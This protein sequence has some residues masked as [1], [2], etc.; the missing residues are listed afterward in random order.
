M[1]STIL[2]IKFDTETRDRLKALGR[3]R[4]RATHWLIKRAVDQ[5]LAR[6]E[7]AERERLEDDVRWD[8]YQ[9]TAEAIPNQR[10][11]SWLDELA[12]GQ[13]TSWRR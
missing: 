1:K 10:V 13:R 9:A 11:M 4:D 12:N 7:Q 6:E 3:K 8:R 5:Y 2:G